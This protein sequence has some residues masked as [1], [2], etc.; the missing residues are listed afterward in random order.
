MRYHGFF[1]R[2][3]G[4]YIK[5]RHRRL[6]VD[7]TTKVRFE[8]RKF[9]AGTSVVLKATNVCIVP[10]S[11]LFFTQQRKTNSRRP[12]LVQNTSAARLSAIV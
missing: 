1:P 10:V 3:E 12:I 11:A 4:Q 5:V 9:I 7:A 8:K 2:T 6:L